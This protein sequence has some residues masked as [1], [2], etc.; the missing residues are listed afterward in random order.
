MQVYGVLILKSFH[1]V[2]ELVN[3][4]K[5]IQKVG[6]LAAYVLLTVCIIIGRTFPPGDLF[7][8]GG[9]EKCQHQKRPISKMDNIP[10]EG[11]CDNDLNFWSLF[12]CW[13]RTNND[14][15]VLVRSLLF[16]GVLSQQFSIILSDGYKILSGGYPHNLYYFLCDGIYPHL[17]ILNFCFIHVK[18]VTSFRT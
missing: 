13:P 11:W 7:R 15:N 6:S 17:D 5:S 8:T 9:T 16:G 1:T 18:I 14:L 3:I 12:A 4:E 2:S 10:Y